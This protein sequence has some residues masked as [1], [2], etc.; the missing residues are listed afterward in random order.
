MSKYFPVGLKLDDTQ[1]PM[2]ILQCARLDW[3]TESG[4][5]VTL[6]LQTAKS[7]G[8]DDMILVHAKHVPSNRTVSLFSLVYRPGNPYPVR[9]Q[10]KDEEL[11]KFLRKSYH[12][13][14]FARALSM[15]AAV[16]VQGH[17]VTNEWV[18][19][20]PSEFRTKLSDVF[21]LGIVKSEVLNLVVG[22]S[23][24]DGKGLDSGEIQEEKE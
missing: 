23:E 2:E 14:G 24:A 16:N 17:T 19:D 9:I 12:E 21:N 20:T 22:T 1:T 6:I 3:E 4:G 18:S 13:P 8:D 10:P 11:P 15:A 5:L 7:K